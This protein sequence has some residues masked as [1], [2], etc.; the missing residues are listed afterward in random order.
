MTNSR[1]TDPEVLEDRFPV[2]LE[3]F[4]IRRGSGGAGRWSGGDGVVRRLRVLEPITVALL[5]GSRRQPPFGLAGGEPGCCGVNSLQRVGGPSERLP[6]SWQRQLDCGDL[7]EIATPGG[8]GYGLPP[9]A[10]G[11][12]RPDR[13]AALPATDP[14]LSDARS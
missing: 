1:L 7:L 9:S 10:G 11:S 14:E 6:G 3:A 12:S 13:A 5:S 4:S 2:R 8:G